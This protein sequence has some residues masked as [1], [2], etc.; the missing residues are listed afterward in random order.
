ML[1]CVLERGLFAPFLGRA[2]AAV[3]ADLVEEA[4]DL[5]VMIVR[6]AELDRDL[7]ARA[8]PSFEVDLDPG[9]AQMLARAQDFAEGRHLER[10]MVHRARA[11]LV[12]EPADQ[13]EAMVI[14]VAAEKYE[15]A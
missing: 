9:A 4:V 2:H 11:G 15:S 1:D 13:R 12:L 14:G 3:A 10:E 5:E 7:A 6:I 8:P